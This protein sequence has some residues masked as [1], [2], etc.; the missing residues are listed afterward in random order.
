MSI[1]FSDMKWPELE[2]AKKKNTVIL[3]PVG[4]IEEHGHH[5]P[6]STDSEIAA[7]VAKTV[8]ERIKDEIPVLVLPTVWTGYHGVPV[9]NWPGSIRLE[10]ATLKNL[11]FDICASICRNGFKKIL[12]V[13]GHGQNP[14]I[15]EMVC[16]KIA[17]T[18]GVNP[19]LTSVWSMIGKEGA[20]IRKSKTGGMAGHGDELETALMLAINEDLVDMTKAEDE[21]AVYHNKFVA[22]DLYPEHEMIKGVYWSTWAV[23]Q[24][25]TGILGDA[26]AATKETGEKLLE[27]MIKNYCE[28]ITLYY[29]HC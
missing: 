24:S 27:L 3:L 11:V 9:S 18:F 14:A 25:R 28:L 15:L 12:I 6:I 4:M 17:D 10:P 20:K 23:Q 16:R 13:N 7:Y 22:G 2:E 19:V 26:T 21:T 5:L 29:N 8:A 1:Y